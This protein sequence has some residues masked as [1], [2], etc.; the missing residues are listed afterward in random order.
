M[1]LSCSAVIVF[2]TVW[3]IVLNMVG[4]DRYGV[5]PCLLSWA[6]VV[7]SALNSI[8]GIVR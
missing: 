7:A 5:N 6:T 2:G 3:G 1:V 4:S 8:V